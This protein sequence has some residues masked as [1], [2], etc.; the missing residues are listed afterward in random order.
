[1]PASSKP[2]A[3]NRPVIS[4]Q[5]LGTPPRALA[6]AGA[7]AAAPGIAEL[8]KAATPATCRRPLRDKSQLMKL[9]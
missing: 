4:K 2:A 7:W 5:I 9:E 6:W 1:M 8:A 3:D